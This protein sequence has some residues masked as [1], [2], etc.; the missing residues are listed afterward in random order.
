MKKQAAKSVANKPAA[1]KPVADQPAE[2]G[3]GEAAARPSTGLVLLLMAAVLGVA[4]LGYTTTG[5]PD[6][7]T[8]AAKALA[9]ERETAGAGS[10]MPDAAQLAAMVEKLAQRLKAEPDD[11][12]GWAMLGR[13]QLV[14]G[15]PGDAV[16]AYQRALALSPDDASLLAD[17][18]DALAMKNGRTL[19]GEPTKL[20]SRALMLDPSHGKALALAGS[21]AFERSDYV[22]A[23]AHWEKL[24]AVS[25]P[26]AEFTAQVRASVAEARQLAGLAPQAAAAMAPAGAPPQP[27]A[28]AAAPPAASVSGKVTLAAELSARA[29]PEDTVFIVAR[30]AEGTRVPLAVLRR[31]VKDLPISF[32]LDDSLAMAP[33]MKL[34]NFSKV[35]VIARVS[36]SGTAMPEAGDITGQSAV[37]EVGA[38]ALH[39]EMGEVVSKP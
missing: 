31:Q 22:G 14:R 12:K 10:G 21:A 5:T 9:H 36:K 27:G 16:A 23:I 29:A 28:Q 15:L 25:P 8:R 33:A 39:V 34:S 20:L 19:A 13:V 32:T 35:I 6:Y 38:K 2:E 17:A 26:E 7:D 3:L 37:V 11:V 18:A 1:N 24:I 4:A 30:A